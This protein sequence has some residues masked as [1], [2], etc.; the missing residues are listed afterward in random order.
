MSVTPEMYDHPSYY[1][2]KDNPYEC[3]KVLEAWLTPNEFYGFLRGTI[4]KYQSR[5]SKGQSELDAQKCA[6]YSRYLAEWMKRT[7]YVPA[8]KLPAKSSEPPAKVAQGFGVN[9]DRS[10]PQS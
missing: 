10:S 2:G 7:G 4:I 5:T 3:I 1:G 6:W 9:G 8:E